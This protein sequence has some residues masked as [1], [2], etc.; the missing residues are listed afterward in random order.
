MRLSL[1]SLALAGLVVGLA[2]CGGDGSK[3]RDRAERPDPSVD[4]TR[5]V[6]AQINAPAS[7][8]S[9]E[10]INDVTFSFSDNDNPAAF[11]DVLQ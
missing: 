5:F 3:N 9:P 1:K 7:K 2:G 6:K 4:F 10:P 11:D 8:S